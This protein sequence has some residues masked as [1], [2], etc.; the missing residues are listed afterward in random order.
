MRFEKKSNWEMLNQIENVVF[1][2][3]FDEMEKNVVVVV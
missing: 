1:N 2:L 3:S